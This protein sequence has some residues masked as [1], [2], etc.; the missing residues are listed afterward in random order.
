MISDHNNVTHMQQN[1]CQTDGLRLTGVW[2]S[3][4][5][6]PASS[7]SENSR[8]ALDAVEGVSRRIDDLANKLGCLGHFDQSEGPRAA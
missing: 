8:R 5:D 1:D 7:L 6:I 4:D 2:N 3:F